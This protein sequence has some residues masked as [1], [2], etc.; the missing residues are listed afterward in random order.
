MRRRARSSSSSSRTSSSSEEFDRRMYHIPIRPTSALSKDTEPEM[1][2][3]ERH[4]YNRDL[5]SDQQ[6]QR[7]YHSV[8]PDQ[9]TPFFE[10]EYQAVHSDQDLY[11]AEY[12]RQLKQDF[13]SFAYEAERV[14]QD[15][16]READA[17]HE[18]AESAERKAQEAEERAYEFE[19]LVKD[20]EKRLA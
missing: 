10:Q 12:S 15:A 3:R 19:L 13:E 17:A 8:S 7:R 11:M 2:Y 14:K 16:I 18:R 4:D 20:A 6:H 5:L 9:R 1:H